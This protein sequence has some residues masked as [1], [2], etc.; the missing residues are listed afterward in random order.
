MSEY[1]VPQT[2]T[3]VVFDEHKG[4]LRIERDRPVVQPQV[5]EV[6]VKVAYSG[7]CRE[8]S[9]YAPEVA[10]STDSSCFAR[11]GLPCA[12]SWWRGLIDSDLHAWCVRF[13]QSLSHSP[14]P[15]T[16]IGS[17]RRGG[18]KAWRLARQAEAA[19]DRRP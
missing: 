9:A 15:R 19:S 6:L 17:S 3:A 2:A 12:P 10:E 8:S 1:D 5:G 16:L 7:V 4:P 14:R 11:R 13:L 18:R